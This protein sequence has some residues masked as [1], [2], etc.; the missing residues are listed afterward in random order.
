MR[1]KA[2]KSGRTPD[3]KDSNP[4]VSTKLPAWNFQN[5]VGPF[6]GIKHMSSNANVNHPGAVIRKGPSAI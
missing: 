2:I 6:Q 4:T 5:S 3:T 1:L